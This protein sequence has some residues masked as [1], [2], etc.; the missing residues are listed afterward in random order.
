M[1][2][3]HKSVLLHETVDMINIKKGGIYV[4]AT[5][6]GGGHSRYMLSK[7][8]DMS[9]YVF[10]QDIYAIDNGRN[11]FANDNRIHFINT[12]FVNV[13]SALQDM[14]IYEIDG[15]IADLGVSSYQL[16]TSERGFSYMKDAPLDMRMDTGSSLTARDVVNTYSRD[17]LKRI[18]R[19]YS[20]EKWADKIATIIV[21][22]REKTPINTTFELVDVIERA[23]PKKLR[24]KN[25][26]PAKRTFQA[27]R[28]ETNNELGILEKFVN[29][30]FDM[31][32][33]GGRMSIITFHSLE[34]RLIKNIYKDLVG[35]CICPSEFPVCMCGRTEKARIITK[36]PIIP[37][38]EELQENARARSAKLRVIEKI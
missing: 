30:A 14:G 28:I 18:I 11:N 6:G 31:L 33:I 15:I 34:D 17:E 35:G 22:T 21:E 19:L 7:I 27:I 10:D 12:N 25:K 32:K 2:Y 36:K 38:D 9:L 20:E 4:D 8:D 37:T 16:D 29:D 26:H 3:E 5:F 13:K 24:D 23:I 1:I